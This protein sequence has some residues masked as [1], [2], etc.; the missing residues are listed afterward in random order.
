VNTIAPTIPMMTSVA[1]MMSAM[2]LYLHSFEPLA[3]LEFL[4][5]V[6]PASERGRFAASFGLVRVV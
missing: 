5:R 3:A 2:F 4:W 6:S 1:P